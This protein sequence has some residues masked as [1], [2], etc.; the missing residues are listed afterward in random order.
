MRWGGRDGGSSSGHRWRS[1]SIVS[2][3]L[4]GVFIGVTHVGAFYQIMLGAVGIGD[5]RLCKRC[6][7]RSHNRYGNREETDPSFLEVQMSDRI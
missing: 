6:D 3:P 7:R 1:D 4:H 2:D 5:T